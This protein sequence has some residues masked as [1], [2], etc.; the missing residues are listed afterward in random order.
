MQVIIQSHDFTL[1]RGLESFIQKQAQKAM[2]SYSDRIERLVVRLKKVNQPNG[3][4]D[5]QCCVEV[6]LPKQ[7]NVVVIKRSS[8][9]YSTIRKTIARAGRTTLRQ[10]GRRRAGRMRNRAGKLSVLHMNELPELG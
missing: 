9:A 8:D 5:P 7:P 4:S 2:G 3:S 10:L 1:T 6:Q